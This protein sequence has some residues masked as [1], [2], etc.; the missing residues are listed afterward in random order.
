MEA[1]NRSIRTRLGLLICLSGIVTGILAGL[2]AMSIAQKTSY[3]GTLTRYDLSYYRWLDRCDGATEYH[4]ST[5]MQLQLN[6]R[7]V[8]IDMSGTASCPFMKFTG[9]LSFSEPQ[10]EV[11]GTLD[12]EEKAVLFDAAMGTIS[13]ELNGTYILLAPVDTF[14]ETTSLMFITDHRGAKNNVSFCDGGNA[15]DVAKLFVPGSQ[16]LSL[17]PHCDPTGMQI[18]PS[19]KQTANGTLVSFEAQFAITA[20]VDASSYVKAI[21]GDA[22]AAHIVF[23]NLVY[24]FTLEDTRLDVLFDPPKI[25]CGEWSTVTVKV[26]NAKGEVMTDYDGGAEIKIVASESTYDITRMQSVQSVL[27]TK[28]TSQ[29]QFIF[30][31]KQPFSSSTVITSETPISGKLVLEAKLD[32]FSVPSVRKTL[33][34]CSPLDFSI[35]RIELQQGIVDRDR[36][37]DIEYKPG[38]MRTF[39]PLP[40]IA[41]HPTVLRIFPQ[42]E[43]P[44][45]IQFDHVASLSEFTA[46][47]EVKRDGS[48]AG[49]FTLPLCASGNSYIFKDTYSDA[50]RNS[51]SDALGARLLLSTELTPGNYS[52]KV[53]LH[54]TTVVRERDEDLANNTLTIETPFVATKQASIRL[55]K[56]LSLGEAPL[57][58]PWDYTWDVLWTKLPI[59]RSQAVFNDP[60]QI[61]IQLARAAETVS[62]PVLTRYHNLWNQNNPNDQR[63]Y[64]I[65]FADQALVERT[66]RNPTGGCAES[67][68]GRVAIVTP[69]GWKAAVHELGHLLGLCDTYKTP[70]WATYDGEPN[71]RRRDAE[72]LGNPI[73]TGNIDLLSNPMR[74]SGPGNVLFD[75]MGAGS[76][77][78]RVEWDFLYRKHF[79]SGGN[80]FAP[81]SPLTGTF[82]AISGEV[83]KTD[84]AYFSPFI[85]LD[86]IPLAPD[87]V[88]GFYS[89]AF[90]GR[91]NS[92]LSRWSFNVVFNVPDGGDRDRVPFSTT[93]ALPEGAERV[94]LVRIDSVTGASHV[95]ATRSF[96]GSAPTVHILE[97]KTGP[98]LT[99]DVTLRWTASDPD[100]D[101]LVY[102]VLFSPDGKEQIVAGVLLKDTTFVI[103]TARLR[104]SSAAYF[105]VIA[106]DGVHEGRAVSEPLVVTDVREQ[107]EPLAGGA[108]SIVL[109]ANYPNPFSSTTALRYSIPRAGRVRIT[110]KDLLGRVVAVLADKEQASGSFTVFFDAMRLPSGVYRATL[111]ACGSRV[112]RTMLH[113]N[114]MR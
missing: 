60:N 108:S 40:L 37:V 92:L 110:V 5:K 82:V 32:N 58:V 39:D 107:S 27:I 42:Y 50:E 25:R 95:L 64:L 79:Q 113:V 65:A 90:Y 78:D 80:G 14:L 31:P 48:P 7:S 35:K 105:T 59:Q 91:F 98:Q 70:L 45:N 18:N 15:Y 63:Q 2:P 74:G 68:S 69:D 29:P 6:Q 1:C 56:C 51:L 73:Q 17:K 23:I 101:P 112:M 85:M 93:L 13:A 102:D 87:T 76:G 66:C 55:V 4:D 22:H 9:V 88:G 111:E 83:T 84:S 94:S 34:V 38:V 52:F 57:V 100:G 62:F 53:T 24:S 99:G 71:P 61:D 81:E 97:P 109:D 11:S 47:V 44:N 104:P 33:E 77:V 89:I 67:V 30:T 72:A 19:T 16:P 28:G 3:R 75:L 36:S 49:S 26:K 41:E 43:N 21:N 8:A 12:A 20:V 46:D 103:N 114:T 54:N 96:S 86:R 106:N 10:S